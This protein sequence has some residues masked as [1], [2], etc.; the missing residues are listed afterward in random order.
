MSA[1]KKQ[2]VVK[3]F[4]GF[5]LAFCGHEPAQTSRDDSDA[6]TRFDSF[7]AA[8]KAALNGALREGFFSIEKLQYL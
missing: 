5:Y 2:Y 8:K 3:D 6:A 4:Y 1:S 7:D